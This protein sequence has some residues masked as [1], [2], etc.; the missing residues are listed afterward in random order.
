MQALPFAVLLIVSPFPRAAVLRLICL[1]TAFMIAAIGWR[2]LAPP[3][4]PCRW[5][6]ALWG[7]VVIA[8]LYFA[9]DPAYSLGEVRREG[10]YALAAFVA[11]FAWTR[12]EARLRLSCAAVLAGFAAMSCSALLGAYLRKGDWPSDAYYGGVGAVS[13]YLV[14]VGPVLALSVELFWR[15]HAS[16][17]WGVAAGLFLATTLLC[18]QRALWPAIGLQAALVCVW[19]CQSKTVSVRP[20]RLVITL[21]IL[22]ALIGG[23]MYVSERY[24]TGGDPDS[25]S[26]MW[27]DLR[28]RVWQ[29]VGEEILAHP[30]IG[31]GFGQGVLKR[32]YPAL[33]APGDTALWRPYD[34]HAESRVFWHPHNLVLN[35]GISAGVPGMIAVLGLFAALAWRFWQVALRGEHLARLCGLAGAAMVTGVFARNMTNDLFVSGGAL[36]F[37][38]LAGML[39]GYATRQVR[40]PRP[41]P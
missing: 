15:G 14:T 17:W 37:W 13:N 9:V 10:F 8:S 3:P 34:G 4:V 38:A 18:A 7:G 32:A 41:E 33:L 26:T 30:L 23:G 24:R 16:R 12:D 25:P 11:F 21:V 40:F 5:A 36:L 29:K 28:P 20:L 19:L 2:Q 27:T 39:F 22:L 1:A 35:Y 31:A 6:I